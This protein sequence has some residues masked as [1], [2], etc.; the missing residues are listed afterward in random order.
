M[1]AG[2]KRLTSTGSTATRTSSVSALNSPRF[3]EMAPKSYASGAPALPEG[4]GGSAGLTLSTKV[5]VRPHHHDAEPL[6]KLVRK[7][8][9]R[10]VS[11]EED[12][13]LLKE[14]AWR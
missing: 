12:V 5:L 13:A 2:P 11:G 4:L 7:P 1:R 3:P 14:V 10:A 6:T 8:E 9:D